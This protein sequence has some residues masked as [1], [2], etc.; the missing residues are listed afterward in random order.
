LDLDPSFM[1]RFDVIITME[2]R[3]EAAKDRAVAETVFD[4]VREAQEA[5]AGERD[6]FDTLDRPVEPQVARAWIAHARDEVTPRLQPGQREQVAEWYADEIRQLT[7]TDA[8]DDLPAPSTAREIEAA[9]RLATAFARCRL[10][11]EVGDDDIDR[12]CSLIQR[13]LGQTVEDGVFVTQ[14]L[15]GAE[16]YSQK[17]RRKKIRETI[18]EAEEPISSEGISAETGIDKGTVEGDLQAL[19]R[20]RLIYEPDRTGFYDVV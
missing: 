11:E 13:I 5:E 8:E 19:K 2:D 3:P 4:G 12:A 14:H 20:K 7:G 18:E 16:T 17:Q 1:D 15:R 6:E 9:L 10:R